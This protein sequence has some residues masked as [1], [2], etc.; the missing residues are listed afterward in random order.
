MVVIRTQQMKALDSI[1]LRRFEDELVAHSKDFSPRLAETLG[2]EQLRVAVRA[3]MHRAD[4][5]G[6]TYRGPIRLFVELAFLCGSAFDADPQYPLLG[7][8][9]GSGADQMT[10]AERMHH[11]FSDYVD[12]VCGLGNSNVR[13]ALMKLLMYARTPITTFPNGFVPGML[14]Q[15][16]RVFPEK[17]AY[18]GAE[19][20]NAM[21]Q[22]AIGEAR[23]RGFTTHR[24]G[25]LLV[26]LMFALGQG[27][28]EDP[29]YPWIS[30]TLSDSRIID[31]ANRAERLE[32]KA[33]TWL[34][35][36]LANEDEVSG[37]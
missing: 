6:F 17:V 18:V 30:S 27:C 24:Q 32:R 26:A 8:I 5:H 28:S 9:L 37:T 4:S 21:I 13:T 31:A 1:A 15:L 34:E 16:H 36:V 11:A 22:K 12:T 3:A 14:E 29:L 7:Q 20:L 33:V 19:G 2:D 25:A 10:R 35:H 23:S